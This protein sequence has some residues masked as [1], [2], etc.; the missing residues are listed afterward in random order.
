MDVG[1]GKQGLWPPWIFMH[2]TDKIE[3]TGL[4]FSVNSHLQ[5]FL[6]TPLA[7]LIFF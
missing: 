4:V 2:D 6:P 3:G 1:S 5:I 7:E